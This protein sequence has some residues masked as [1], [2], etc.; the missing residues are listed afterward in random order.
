MRARSGVHRRDHRPCISRMRLVESP[1]GVSLA[2]RE[3]FGPTDLGGPPDG[4]AFDAF[5]SLWCT[6]VMVDQLI[7]ADAARRQA[8][9]ARRRGTGGIAEPAAQDEGRQ[10]QARGHASC[11]RYSRA[12]DGEHHL[13]RRRP[14][15]GLSGQPDGHDHPSFPALRRPGCPWRIGTSPTEHPTC[16]RRSPPCR[17]SSSTCRST[18]KTTCC[19][20]PPAF[21]PKIQYFTHDNTYEQIEPFFPG[22]KKE[23]LPDGEGW[24]VELVQAVDPQRHAPGRALPLPQDHE[25][26]A[27]QRSAR[28]R[29]TRCRSNGASSPA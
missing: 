17:A 19:R 9:A 13:R 1:R 29:S 3:V 14:A 7:R 10:L 18:S 24:A 12:L 5:G 16:Q 20:D 26:G 15:N 2:Q 25:Q 21:A 28:S 22:L 11:A 8:A 4:I 6:L 23:D 27:G